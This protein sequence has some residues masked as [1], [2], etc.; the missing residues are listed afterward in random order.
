MRQTATHLKGRL[1]EVVEGGVAGC[2]GHPIDGEGADSTLARRVWGG[3]GGRGSRGSGWG[4]WWCGARDGVSEWGVGCWGGMG[5]EVV[6][7]R[8]LG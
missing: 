1:C 3:A 7:S 4:V 8:S 2:S 6:G 5:Q